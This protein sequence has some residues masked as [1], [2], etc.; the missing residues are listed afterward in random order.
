MA[1]APRERGVEL[2]GSNGPQLFL[3]YS[4]KDD[5]VVSRLARN[6]NT[7]GVDVWFDAWE[8]RVGDDLHQRIADAIA[9]SKYVAV[10]VSG[11]F[12]S[13]KWTRG[14]V[15]QALSR[16]KREARSLVLPLLI[17][18][19][20]PPPLLED[21]KF[22]NFTGDHYFASLVRLV[23][24]IHGLESQAVEEGLSRIEPRNMSECIEVLRFTGFEPYL[25]VDTKTLEAIK[26]AGGSGTGDKVRFDPQRIMANPNASPALRQLMARLID[27]WGS[28]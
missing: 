17:E 23:G 24:L 22:L 7:C 4:S 27:D 21:K 2:L 5:Q 6:L 20:L 26:N 16:E 19:V 14:E 28:E 18:D 10:V 12:D 15:S 11:G 13:S 1:E 9:K 3:S 25:I 8:L